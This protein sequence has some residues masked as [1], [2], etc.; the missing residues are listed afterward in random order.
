MGPK[1]A[2]NKKGAA[3]A[4]PKPTAPDSAP[5]VA[6][7]RALSKIAAEKLLAKKRAHNK[8]RKLAKAAA[9]AAKRVVA[10]VEEVKSDEAD[11]ESEA[12]DSTS[13]AELISSSEEEPGVV[14]RAKRSMKEKLK[15][16]EELLHKRE[17]ELRKSEVEIARRDADATRVRSA[18][19]GADPGSATLRGSYDGERTRCVWVAA[20]AGNSYIVEYMSAADARLHARANLQIIL[21]PQMYA[22][23]LNRA[24]KRKF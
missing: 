10:P 22:A 8:K 14:L 5:A 7:A 13:D 17:V 3:V 24:V 9:A 19:R 11:D 16:L 23:L 12:S 6:G 4:A 18:S 1:T 20:P 2:G 15:E 21:T